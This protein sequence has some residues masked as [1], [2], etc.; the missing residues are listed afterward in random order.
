MLLPR[1]TSEKVSKDSGA[2]LALAHPGVHAAPGLLMQ[3]EH[4][5]LT[6]Q[7]SPASSTHSLLQLLVPSTQH[8]G[9]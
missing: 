8:H 9:R 2:P 4:M 7:A 3:V 6:L 5:K 1:A